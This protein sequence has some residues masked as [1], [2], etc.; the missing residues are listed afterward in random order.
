[1]APLQCLRAHV[2]VSPTAYPK[3]G[4]AFALPFAHVFG[5][6]RPRR[7]G[8]AS[9]DRPVSLAAALMSA[10]LVLPAGGDAGGARRMWDRGDVGRMKVSGSAR[11][12][13]LV[14]RVDPA[15]LVAP[16]A[17]PGGGRLNRFRWVVLTTATGL[18]PHAPAESRREQLFLFRGHRAAQR[19]HSDR[20]RAGGL[21]PRRFQRPLEPHRFRRR[22]ETRELG[23]RLSGACARARPPA[24]ANMSPLEINAAVFG[25]YL[26]YLVVY[27]QISVCSLVIWLFGY[28]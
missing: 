21:E 11:S 13:I 9:T 27:S 4:P 15:R 16:R 10:P 22:E 28:L 12:L 5:G 14:W 2:F 20:R 19:R 3:Q 26:V 24:G 25:V 1:M 6:R 7:R 8:L 17:R 23:W 18:E